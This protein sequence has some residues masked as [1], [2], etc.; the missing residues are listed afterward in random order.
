MWI[1]EYMTGRSI[2][3]E[4]SAT[5]E[6]RASSGGNVAVSSTRDYQSVPIISPAGI[7]YVPAVGSRTVVLPAEG[8]TVCLGVISPSPEELEA[9]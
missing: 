2:S 1:S 6:I 4:G 3:G 7:A 8:G 9:G 5:G